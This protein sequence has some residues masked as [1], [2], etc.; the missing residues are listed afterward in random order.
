MKK[1]IILFLALVALAQPA[2]TAEET[3]LYCADEMVTGFYKDKEDGQW[4]ETSFHPERF[5]IQVKGD[6]ESL[7]VHDTP[8]E[9]HTFDSQPGVTVH[10]KA[11]YK[12]LS[13]GFQIHP[14]SG[15]YV[16][17]KMSRYGLAS[18]PQEHHGTDSLQA[19]KCERF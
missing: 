17:A 13:W 8:L 11:T 6:W 18:L 10:C 14:A 3:V 19:G 15:R 12:W 7:R 5:S 2:W 1:S 4:E 16:F 9:C